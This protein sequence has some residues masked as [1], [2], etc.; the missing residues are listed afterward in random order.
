MDADPGTGEDIRPFAAL[1]ALLRDR[2]LSAPALLAADADY[3]DLDAPL[4][5]AHDRDPGLP[6]EGSMLFPPSPELWG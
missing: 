3:V 6:F 5:L 2:G 1:T 4:L